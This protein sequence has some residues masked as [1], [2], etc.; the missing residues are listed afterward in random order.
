[1][2]EMQGLG[3]RIVSTMRMGL[4]AGMLALLASCGGGSGDS[5]RV[6]TDACAASPHVEWTVGSATCSGSLEQGRPG[7]E[8]L[9]TD[10]RGTRGRSYFTCRAG[11]WAP[12]VDTATCQVPAGGERQVAVSVQADAGGRV[13]EYISD[14]FLELGR[15]FNGIPGLNGFFLVSA[16][17]AYTPVGSGENAFFHG[18]NWSNF[19]T[20]TFDVSGYSG[21]GDYDAEIVS[22]EVDL[23]E[24]VGKTLRSNG[25]FENVLAYGHPYETAIPGHDRATA[26]PLPLTPGSFTGRVRLRD[27]EVIGI[28]FDVP[29]EVLFRQAPTAS[30]QN[31]F[32]LGNF[33]VRADG[34]MS[35]NID[36]T[37]VVPIF[38][39]A[40]YR[41][42]FSGTASFAEITN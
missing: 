35:L 3:M 4:A 39:A 36:E 14:A 6:L 30:G 17:P 2:N 18:A 24:Y 28:E 8:L 12:H 26:N 29:I 1:M 40:R 20:V 33:A 23:Y 9:V 16:L 13:Y 42:D 10:S 7:R 37:Q 5:E 19:A 32:Y 41:W 27:D 11:T 21:V 25:T 38:G 31:V 34:G 15:S 22:V